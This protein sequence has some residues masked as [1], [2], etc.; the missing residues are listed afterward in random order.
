MNFLEFV[1][2]K[3]A[4]VSID[5]H[6]GGFFFNKV[7]LLKKLKWRETASFKALYGGLSEKNDPALSSSVY[8]FPVDNNGL[9]I[10]YALGNK[11]YM[12]A[13]VG[14]ENIFKFVR[15]DFVKRLSYLNHPDIAPF[16][17]RVKIKFD[18]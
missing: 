6:F 10:T 12:E 2:D 16:G 17:V 11:P 15:V 9:P 1:S 18:F 14:V 4:S 7:P 13:S 3:Y 5:Q 8:Q